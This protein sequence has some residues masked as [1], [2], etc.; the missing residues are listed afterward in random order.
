MYFLCFNMCFNHSWK[1]PKVGNIGRKPLVNLPTLIVR[2][3]RVPCH[4][5]F[6]NL[7]ATPIGDARSR[8]CL[9]CFDCIRKDLVT[10]NL[11]KIFVIF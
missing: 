4:V 3:P 11:Y 10:N 9:C 1:L 5:N 7:L 6:D 8:C 2:Q